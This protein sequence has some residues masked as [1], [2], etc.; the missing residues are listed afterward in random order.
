MADCCVVQLPWRGAVFGSACNG[1][2]KDNRALGLLEENK[3]GFMSARVTADVVQIMVR[4][5]E[6]VVNARR[7]A[8][9]FGTEELLVVRLLI[10]K[11]NI[12]K[13]TNRPYGSCLKGIA[14]KG[15]CLD[16]LIDFSLLWVPALQC[17]DKNARA[18]Q[19]TPD[20]PFHKWTAE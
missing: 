9:A 2:S 14:F 11:K 17:P 8:N 6:S 5:E 18:L 20:S 13:S 15:R 10:C 12:L 4:V 16:T 1:D 7:R 3:A 19:W